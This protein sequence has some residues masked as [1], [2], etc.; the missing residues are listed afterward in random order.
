MLSFASGC[1]LFAKKKLQMIFLFY[2]NAEA[3]GVLRRGQ[4]QKKHK[5]ACKH[6]KQTLCLSFKTQL[7]TKLYIKNKYILFLQSYYIS[8]CIIVEQ[9]VFLNI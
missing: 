6:I 4:L 3:A 5:H 8:I 2:R 1:W 9:H 7:Y